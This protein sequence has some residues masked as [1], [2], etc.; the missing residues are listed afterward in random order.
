MPEKNKMLLYIIFDN[1]ANNLIGEVAIRK[2]KDSP[3]GQFSCWINENY[4]GGGRFQEAIKLITRTFFA[5]NPQEKSFNAHV[6]LWNKRC[7]KALLNANFTDVKFYYN[8]DGKPTRHI[9]E[10]INP[11]HK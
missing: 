2:E 4:W 10:M 7:H 8:K 9:M 11:N 1:K 3:V 6:R 5:L